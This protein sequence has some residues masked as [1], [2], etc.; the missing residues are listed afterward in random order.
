VPEPGR[1]PAV[2]DCESGLLCRCDSCDSAVCQRVRRESEACSDPFTLCEEHT[3]CRAGV[4]VALD[5]LGLYE[6]KCMP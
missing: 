5:S 2:P 4:C 6:M 3:E 1:S